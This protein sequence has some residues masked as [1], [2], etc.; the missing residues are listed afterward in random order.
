M[1]RIASHRGGTLEFGDSTHAGFTATAQMP[2]DEVEFDLHPTRDGAIIVHHDATLDRTTDRTG[3]IAQMTLADV[4]AARISYGHGTGPITLE[5]LC[6]IFQ[7]SPVAFR[8]E[9][10]PGV[11]ARPYPDFVPRVVA[12][13]TAQGR[14]ATTTFSSFLLESLDEIGAAS[15]QPRL[16]LVSTPVLEQLGLPALLKVA[17]DHGLPEIGLHIDAV[18]ADIAA[19]TQDAGL[20]IGAWAAH[21]PTQIT[22]ALDLGLKVFTTDR[23]SLAIAIRKNRP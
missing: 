17:K 5:Q 18:T 12:M 20:A 21:T 2:L 8:C 7:N 13:L 11:D 6:A 1:T 10:K 22:K 23:P 19:R 9:I 16:W 15:S 3:A 4:Q 14:L